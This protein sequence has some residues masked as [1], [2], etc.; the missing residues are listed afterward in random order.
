MLFPWFSYGFPSV[1]QRDIAGSASIL[2]LSVHRIKLRDGVLQRGGGGL[3]DVEGMM[4]CDD[5]VISIHI[6]IHLV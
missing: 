6:Y 5:E 2:Q 4:R 1:S 3:G